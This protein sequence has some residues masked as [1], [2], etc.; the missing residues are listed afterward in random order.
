MS[1]SSEIS[2]YE[3]NF[4][5]RGQLIRVYIKTPVIKTISPIEGDLE[6]S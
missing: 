6:T 5:L 3:L 1:I 4:I 2:N